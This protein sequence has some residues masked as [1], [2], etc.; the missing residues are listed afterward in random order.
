MNEMTKPEG[1]AAQAGVGYVCSTIPRRNAC[2]STCGPPWA[3]SWRTSPRTT[4]C[5]A[6]CS[7]GAGNKA[8]VSGADISRFGE[9]R[10]SEE[11]VAHYNETTEKANHALYAY[12]KPSR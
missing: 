4:S 8:F 2:R 1:A 9:E 3:A 11:A 6:S 12:P 10:S 7:P 5:A